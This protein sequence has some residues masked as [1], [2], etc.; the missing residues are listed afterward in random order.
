MFACA[1]AP[2]GS[3]KHRYCDAE[4]DDAHAIAAAVHQ[5]LSS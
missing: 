5:P 3:G 4:D 1:C 2:L